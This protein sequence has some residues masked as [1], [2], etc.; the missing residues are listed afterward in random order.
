MNNIIEEDSFIVNETLLYAREGIWLQVLETLGNPNNA[1]KAYLINVIPEERRWG[2][3]HQA[4]YWK[5]EDILK[6]LLK[7][8]QC[9]PT[10]MTKVY[11]TETGEKAQDSVAEIATKHKFDAALKI[12]EGRTFATQDTDTFLPAYSNIDKCG[13]SIIAITLAAYKMTFHPDKVDPNLQVVDVLQSIFQT[14]DTTKAWEKIRDII[15]DC[16]LVV[17]EFKKI[18]NSRN[19]AEFY[20]AFIK[21]YTD[22]DTRF[23]DKLNTALR[24][25]KVA[26]YRPSGNDLALGPF[27]TTFHMILLFWKKLP[28]ERGITYRQVLLSDGDLQRYQEGATFSWAAFVSSALEYDNAINFPTVEGSGDNNVMFK[29]DNKRDSLWCPRN[30][31][32][33]STK[34]ETERLYPIGARFKVNKRTL[35][36]PCTEINLELL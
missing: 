14:M 13:K 15:Y 16:A 32:E 5:D 23:Y 4:L 34:E 10:I 24:R 20:E 17:D 12:L 19:R 11:T 1:K 27:I 18:G 28:R 33:F 35:K 22:E 25:Q 26:N 36:G 31:S 29:I 21:V 30:I 2:I 6:T 9:D 7:F 8:P 3:L